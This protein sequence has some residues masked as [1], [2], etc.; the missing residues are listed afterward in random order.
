MIKSGRPELDG[1]LGICLGATSSKQ[2]GTLV[3]HSHCT[4]FKNEVT[5]LIRL[6]YETGQLPLTFAFSSMQVNLNPKVLRHTDKNSSLSYTACL[7]DF[8]RGMFIACE[9]ILDTFQQLTLFDGPKV[10][11]VTPHTGTRWSLVLFLHNRVDLL[12]AEQ[13]FQLA[14]M[15]FC[16]TAHGASDI[17]QNSNPVNANDTTPP[18]ERHKVIAI[19]WT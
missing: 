11:Y 19:E 17:E 7:G 10:H 1:S 2:T 4:E 3:I 14:N 5:E 15:G 9:Q 6:L 13:R 16:M 12:S 18:E 8:E